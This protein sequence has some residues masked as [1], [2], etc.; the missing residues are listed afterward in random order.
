MVN[1]VELFSPCEKFFAFHFHPICLHQVPACCPASQ[2]HSILICGETKA[3]EESKK[4][5]KTVAKKREALD[6]YSFPFV[7]AWFG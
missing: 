7:T 4:K 3:P 2:S 5:R 6:L 1:T